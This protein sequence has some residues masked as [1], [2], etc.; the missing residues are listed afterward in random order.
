M[1][2]EIKPALTYAQN[3][4]IEGVNNQAAERDVD[5]VMDFIENFI[6]TYTDY[7]EDGKINLFAVEAHPNLRQKEAQVAFVLINLTG[8]T[9]SELNAEL[10]L[11]VEDFGVS[12]EAMDWTIPSEFLG[13]WEDGY[14]ILVVDNVKMTGSP[15]QMAYGIGEISLEVGEITVRHPR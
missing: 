6:Q 4:A 13:N 7:F 3:Q 11:E 2:R 5:Q 10:Q 14:A 8:E 12:F 1:A 15:T 9:I